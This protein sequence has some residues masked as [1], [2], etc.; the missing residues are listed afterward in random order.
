MLC[1]HP[2]QS[3]NDPRLKGFTFRSTTNE[4]L[5]HTVTSAGIRLLLNVPASYNPALPSRLIIYT[6]PNGNSIEWTEG[7]LLEAG[8]DWHYG[9]QQV[10]A[11]VRWLR[12]HDTA[13]N[14]I[15]AY[16]EA[17]GK[18]FPGWK[19]TVDAPGRHF[20][21]VI[22]SVC[23][24]FPEVKEISLISHSGGGSIIF[25]YLEEEVP[26]PRVVRIAFLD[27][28]YGYKT[29]HAKLFSDLLQN[30]T[31]VSVMVMA[32]NDSLVEY[33]GKRI[34]SD[35]G[36]TW[37]RSRLMI[38]DLSKRMELSDVS[39]DSMIVVR[40]IDKKL[41]FYLHKNRE[42]LIY[43]T[44]QVERNGVIHAMLAATPAEEKEYTYFGDPVYS[45]YIREKVKYP[46]PLMTPM[47]SKEKSTVPYNELFRQQGDNNRFL[48]L[49]MEL[50]WNGE[51][52]E[53]S[54]RMVP[55]EKTAPDLDEKLHHIFFFVAH[56]YLAVGD[57]TSYCRVPLDF[58]R[59]TE[60]AAQYGALLPTRMMVNDIFSAAECRTVPFPLK[61][62]ENQQEKLYQALLHNHIVDSLIS[63]CGD[64]D[65]SIRV[66]TK[67][68]VILSCLLNDSANATRQVIYGWHYPD[69]THIQNR[70]A[71][72]GAKYTDYS[73]GIR[74]VHAQVILDGKLTPLV[75]I[76][77][78][79][80]LF[81]LLSD[82]EE[83]IKKPV[84]VRTG[85]LK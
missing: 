77:S 28:N 17:P 43:H 1:L 33:N 50:L 48:S 5:R 25:S 27:S 78:D 41:S 4:W 67:K 36:G 51:V 61:P 81:R 16:A 32:Y 9:I 29:I 49:C 84:L 34:V 24:L 21:E 6:L 44:V 82:E 8:D 26:D 72:H 75:D 56:D 30:Q 57:D 70:T 11:Q 69:G 45:D 80:I 39:N 18:S 65:V 54:V 40:S 2:L 60:I 31:P 35:T 23:R 14:L 68:D 83:P 12:A 55:I 62:S 58:P 10:G 74:L 63:L 15:I 47:H 38:H 13:T 76:L 73:H 20:R 53:M 52:P 59:A 46:F 66:G 3:Q 37:Y 42:N 19:R 64:D 22:E 79:P 71:V 7:K 85:F